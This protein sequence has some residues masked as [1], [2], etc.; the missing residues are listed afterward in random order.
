MNIRHLACT[1]A[2][3]LLVPLVGGCTTNPRSNDVTKAA[4]VR[5]DR[6]ANL[7]SVHRPV[8]G[9]GYLIPTPLIRQQV[10]YSCG[11][12]SSLSVLRYWK[13]DSRAQQSVY[14]SDHKLTPGTTYGRLPESGLYRVL[15]TTSRNGTDPQPMADYLGRETGLSAEL[16]SD[17]HA[18]S[19]VDD[20]ALRALL[21]AVDRGEPTIVDL[22]AW[23][24]VDH[25]ADLKDWNT[26]W[27][28]GHYI[29]LVG[30]DA[31]NLYFMDPSTRGHYTFIPKT[32]FMTRWHDVV[33]TANVHTSHI[34]IF[35]HKSGTLTPHPSDQNYGTQAY[36]IY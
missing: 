26:D 7:P 24:S 8:P 3:L 22:Q 29:V 2:S 11:D 32:E 16:R 6:Q 17:N 12:V 14:D 19:D 35:I 1:V 20:S 34:A 28:D 36:V 5:A 23:Q 18:G 25:V 33:G 9:G 4:F 21:A 31:T 27:D 30:Y 10:D 15:H 13:W